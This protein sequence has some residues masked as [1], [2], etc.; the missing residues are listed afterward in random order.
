[1]NRRHFCLV[2]ALPAFAAAEKRGI[3]VTPAQAQKLRR[4]VNDAVRKNASTALKAGPWTV[5]A[6][7]PPD[8]ATGPNDDYSEGPYCWPDPKDP[9]AP[10]I[11]K[12]GE[13][14]P[15]RF[16]GNRNDLGSMC[17]AVLALGMGGYLLG[18]QACGE[19]AAR[20]ISAWY[21]DPH[22][23]ESKPGVRPGGAGTQHGTRLGVDRHALDD[24]TRC[25]ARG[26]SRRACL[27]TRLLP[28]CGGGSRILPSG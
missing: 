12:D 6:H 22:A 19:H 1:M 27:I 17:S 20:V 7:R 24:S 21:L 13:R 3:L 15:N 16:M 9:K 5:T 28:A 26:W 4:A 23:N 25:K 8:V 18:D 10:H 11:R 14:N 2:C